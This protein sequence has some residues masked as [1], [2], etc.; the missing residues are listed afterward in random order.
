MRMIQ[1]T[2]SLRIE[3]VIQGKYEPIKSKLKEYQKSL[4][5]DKLKL[6]FDNLT[7][8]TLSY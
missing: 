4:N 2:F 6:S 7:T 1:K 5:E 3:F 8:N